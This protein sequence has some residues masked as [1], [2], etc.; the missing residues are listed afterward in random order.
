MPDSAGSAPFELPR[1]SHCYA[2]DPNKWARPSFSIAEGTCG[3]KAHPGSRIPEARRIAA[4]EEMV[5]TRASEGDGVMQSRQATQN[6][7][8]ATRTRR[9]S[10]DL[11]DRQ[12]VLDLKMAEVLARI[13]RVQSMALEAAGTM[14]SGR[15]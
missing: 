15:R 10:L 5:R 2:D 1:K 7:S 9:V 6:R 12:D 4:P 14:L 13:E 8:K 3:A 11:T